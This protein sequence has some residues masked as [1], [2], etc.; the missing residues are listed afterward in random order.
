M[1]LYYMPG[2]CSLTV[3]IALVMAGRPFEIEPVDY[4]TRKTPTGQ[5]F[6]KINP[7]GYVPALQ[8]PDGRV[9]TEI[10]V[11]LQYLD[12]HIPGAAI[13]PTQFDRRLRAFE[14]L[15]F[16]ATEV[17]KSFSPLFRPNT[18]KS[19]QRVG[20]D[21]LSG[22][23][24]IVEAALQTDPYLSGAEISIVD[25]YLYT[26]CRWLPDQEIDIGQ[27]PRL[28]EHFDDV[29]A[30]SPVR[31]AIANETAHSVEHGQLE[32]IRRAG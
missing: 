29:G 1:K 28:K 3:H 21:H 12:A 19:F 7:K 32:V 26:L 17:H 4:T 25:G 16:L 8:L 31:V 30:L 18:P 13:L 5:D 15:H 9:F 27:W 23:L 20:R 14:W 10:P 22:R 24:K 6:W 11:I 2:A